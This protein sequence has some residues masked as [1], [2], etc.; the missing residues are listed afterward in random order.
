MSKPHSGDDAIAGREAIGRTGPTDEIRVLGVFAVLIRRWRTVFLTAASIV[1]AAVVVSLVKPSTYTAQTILVPAS[2]VRGAGGGTLSSDGGSQGLAQLLGAESPQP[3]QLLD[4][5]LKSHTLADSMVARFGG[6]T[7]SEMEQDRIRSVLKD[8]TEIVKVE[9]GLQVSVSGNDRALVTRMANLLPPLANRV[10]SGL[11]TQVAARREAFLDGQLA[12][13]G[14]RLA[15][16]EQRMVRFQTTQNAPELEEQAKHTMEVAAQLQ[17][18]ILAQEIKIAQLRRT[19]TPNNPEL[20][21]EVS[22]LGGLRGQLAAVTSGDRGNSKI[23][24]SFKDSPELQAA[25]TRLLRDYQRDEQVY[26][27]LSNALA[28]AQVDAHNNLPVLTVL[29]GAI[30]PEHP[31]GLGLPLVLALALVTGLVAGAGLALLR[32]YTSR[33]K[34]DAGNED[35]FLAWEKM[36][37]DLSRGLPRRHAGSRSGGG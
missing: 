22:K 20:Q 28:Q 19:A 8:R 23:L 21:A 3:D 32:E 14:E 6:D 2:A 18:E 31:D 16:S 33:A 10:I 5:V 37:L 26:T 13:A 35:F 36:K 9:G 17:Q 15:A 34:Q 24:L 27:A 30:P 7:L 12:H 1:I 11:S 29:D 25:A 4:V